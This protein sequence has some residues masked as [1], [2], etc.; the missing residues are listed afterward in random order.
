MNENELLGCPKAAQCADEIVRLPFVRN[1]HKEEIIAIIT[2]YFPEP[3]TAPK[4]TEALVATAFELGAESGRIKAARTQSTEAEG[5]K[6]WEW[7]KDLPMEAGTFWWWNGDE[8]S[9]PIHIELGISLPS[10]QVFAQ[11]GQYGWNRAQDVQDMEGWWMPLETP[12]PPSREHRDAAIANEKG[13]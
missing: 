4:S 8:D 2:K 6:E 3:S 13:K 11:I 7:T 9:S 5:D 10:R 12:L 1:G